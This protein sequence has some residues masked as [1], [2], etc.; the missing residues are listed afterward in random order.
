MYVCM[1][2]LSPRIQHY[3]R[4]SDGSMLKWVGVLIDAPVPV[5][6]EIE[7]I[8]WARCRK[9]MPQAR[10]CHTWSTYTLPYAVVFHP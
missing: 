10:G 3:I 4:D 2:N 5:V 7:P 6:K 8:E 9:H 1:Y